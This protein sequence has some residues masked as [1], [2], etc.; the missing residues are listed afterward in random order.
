MSG[1]HDAGQIGIFLFDFSDQLDAIDFR[2][3]IIGDEQIA[4]RALQQGERLIGT[5]SA[6]DVVP[7]VPEY[8]PQ[9]AQYDGLIVHQH[10]GD[11]LR[12]T[13]LAAIG[14]QCR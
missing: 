6:E 4:M 10:N 8:P 7:L 5:G 14:A 9:R 1:Q 11:E 12:V 3:E 2:H 13:S